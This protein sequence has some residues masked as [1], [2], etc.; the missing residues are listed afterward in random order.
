MIMYSMPRG[1]SSRGERTCQSSM[2]RRDLIILCAA[3]VVAWSLP[4]QAQKENP[5]IGFLSPG[6][7][8][9][10]EPFLAGFH[11]GL[12]K[13]GYVEGRNVK[14]EYRWA[15][16]NYD[17]LREQTAELVQRGVTLILATGGQVA[18]TIAKAATS[19]IPIVFIVG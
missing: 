18:A 2:R 15:E 19:T 14:I 5:V 12:N 9:P 17:R 8:G 16:G 3:G 10:F 11:Q 13:A 4:A 6:A 7:P 1:L